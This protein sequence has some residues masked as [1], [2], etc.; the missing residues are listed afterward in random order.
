MQGRIHN[1]PNGAFRMSSR[2]FLCPECQK[3]L[4]TVVTRHSRDKTHARL[5]TAGR[6]V[7]VQRRWNGAFLRCSCGRRTRLSNDLEIVSR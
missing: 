5:V 6:W 4:G 1:K 7:E 3:P 2:P